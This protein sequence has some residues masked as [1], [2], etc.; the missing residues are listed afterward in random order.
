MVSQLKT[1]ANHSSNML[2]VIE[3]TRVHSLEVNGVEMKREG[4]KWKR[5]RGQGGRRRRRQR[6]NE[7]MR[8]NYLCRALVKKI[9][10]IS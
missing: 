5:E 3:C 2:C 7:L 8:D 9:I 4:E 6:K 1:P 10:I